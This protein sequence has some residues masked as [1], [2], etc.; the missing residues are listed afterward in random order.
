VIDQATRQRR[1]AHML[2]SVRTA[3]DMA[4]ASAG[5]WYCADLVCL[6]QWIGDRDQADVQRCCGKDA[7]KKLR[8]LTIESIGL[9]HVLDAT[10]LSIEQLDAL[11]RAYAR[12]PHGMYVL[13]DDALYRHAVLELE[14]VLFDFRPPLT[15]GSK[16]P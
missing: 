14:N 6:G 5:R 4:R 15:T 16:F 10:G 7:V 9:P 3:M 1:Y 2:A 8:D 13:L 12:D 11:Q